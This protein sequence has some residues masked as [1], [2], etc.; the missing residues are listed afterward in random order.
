[1]NRFFRI[2]W[3]LIY[4]RI[5][6]HLQEAVLGIFFSNKRRE[7]RNQDQNIIK[8]AEK[9]LDRINEKFYRS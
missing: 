1:M 3:D 4:I 6:L 8:E 9:E 5:A 2:F 7:R